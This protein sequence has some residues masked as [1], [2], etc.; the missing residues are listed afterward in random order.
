MLSQLNP[1]K[2]CLPRVVNFF[3]AI[4]N[5]Y[6]LVFC[7]TIMERNNRQMLPVIRSTAGGDSVQTCTNPL[8]T[9]FPFDPCMLKRSK[10]FIDPVYQAWEDMSDEELQELRKPTRKELVEDEDD[11]F[12]KGEVP[13]SD[14]VAGL[15]P[16]SFDTHFRSPSSSVGSPPVLFMPDQS[17]LLSRICD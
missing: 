4:T 16:N 1:L 2:I 13:Q 14:T 7:Y 11:D 6:Q 3:A 15:T 10:K 5:K 8:D 12:L 9:F 17:P